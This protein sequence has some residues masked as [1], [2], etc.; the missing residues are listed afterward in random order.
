MPPNVRI[1]DMLNYNGYLSLIIVG[2][3]AIL[4]KSI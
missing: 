3:L 1:F 2:H 4:K